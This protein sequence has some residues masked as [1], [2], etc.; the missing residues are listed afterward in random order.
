[1]RGSFRFQLALRSAGAMTLG[2]VGVSA[3]TF[4][5]LRA[6]LDG[7]IDASILNVASIQ[8][9]SLTDAPSGEMHFHEW[10]LTP[11]EAASVRDLVRY[12][13]VWQSD[14]VS[15]LRSRF[16]TADLPLDRAHLERAADGELVWTDL[17]WEGR[18]I[19]TLYYPLERFGMAHQRHVMQVAARL[20]RRN[21]LLVR[22]AAFLAV[23]SVGLGGATFW[24]AW[25][26]AGRAVRP[27]HEI[28]DQAEAIGGRSLDQRIRAYA[29]T[30]EYRR[31]VDVLNLM[32][33]RIQGAFDAQR[34][35]T[36][37]ASHELR[38][39]LTVMRG[40]LELALMRERAP[41]E[42]RRVL[43]STLEEVVRLSRITEDLL[44]L[45]RS[46][47]GTLGVAPEVADLGEI[48]ER[49][50]ERLAPRAARKGIELELQREPAPALLDSGLAGQAVWNVIENAIKFTPS[51]GAVRVGIRSIPD[52]VALRVEDS[53]PG[54]GDEPSRVFDRFFRADQARTLGVDTSGTGLGLAIVRAIV[55][56]HGGSA[57]A[58][59][60]EEGGGSVEVLFPSRPP[61][62]DEP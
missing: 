23:L 32:L 37:D 60:R 21:A 59:D 36:A 44:S 48:A 1:M 27:V 18:P 33:A 7:E 4:L 30:R 31:L 10:E 8:A 56:A 57:S 40:E 55:E 17:E 5:A 26:L 6:T 51:G 50:V 25:W 61:S 46:D 49:V 19:R 54:F 16:M 42:Y 35:F 9:A 39:P 43:E 47:S 11:D 29:Q 28:I 53:G 45:A 34:R 62:E 3:A 24:G 20:D 15:L 52:G 58:A 2:L 12:A 22:V 38:S 13:Q 14:G 41:A